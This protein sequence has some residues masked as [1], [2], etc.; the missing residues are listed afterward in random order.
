MPQRS[1]FRG[2]P[3][4]KVASAMAKRTPGRPPF[5]FYLIDL[6][7]DHEVDEGLS[8]ECEV[9][10]AIL[11]NRGFRSTVKTAR[12]SSSSRFR[13]WSWRA[14]PR[15]GFVH[16]ATHGGKS[17]ISLIGGNLTW[18][19]VAEKLKII[20]PRLPAGRQRVLSLSCC[21]SEEGYK[22]LRTLLRRHF[23]GCYY[24]GKRRIPFSDA[25]TTWAMFYKRKTIERPHGAVVDRINSFFDEDIIQFGNI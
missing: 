25:M 21:Y 4:K 22:A 3:N 15:V 10:R 1:L 6:P 16:L 9:I 13:A 19:Q 18:G 20:A 12:I 11:S 5:S 23:T 8:T 2:G 14:H 7:S 17:G 24:F